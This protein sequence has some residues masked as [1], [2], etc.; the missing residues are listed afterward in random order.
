MMVFKE[1]MRLYPPAYVI[2]RR[3]LQD[4][5]VEGRRIEKGH[6]VVIN[7]IGMH[8]DPALFPDPERFDP[9]AS[10]RRPRR[11]SRRTPSSPSARARRCASATTSR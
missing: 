7:I 6:L 4:V 9:S 10:P 1:A 5:E 2:A 11:P 3:A 8:H